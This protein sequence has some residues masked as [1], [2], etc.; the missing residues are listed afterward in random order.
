MEIQIQ[1]KKMSG[2]VFEI[3]KRYDEGFLPGRDEAIIAF[4]MEYLH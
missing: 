3:E 1:L 2:A 4:D